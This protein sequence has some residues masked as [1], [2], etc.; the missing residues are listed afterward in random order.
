M[1]CLARAPRA[2]TANDYKRASPGIYNIPIGVPDLTAEL[3]R[4]KA[5]ALVIWGA[6][7]QSLA[8][9]SFA[10]LAAALPNA[11]SV[12]IEAGHVA[13]QSHSAGFNVH[14]V[15]FLKSL[16]MTESHS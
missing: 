1:R 13:Y 10:T 3:S 2:Q 12:V 4:V 9:S 6:H 16:E 11:R 5:P 14:V 15:A 7:D 8:P